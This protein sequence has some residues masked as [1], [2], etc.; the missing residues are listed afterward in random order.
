M[1][2]C[3]VSTGRCT[4]K[5]ANLGEESGE[6]NSQQLGEHLAPSRFNDVLW[7]DAERRRNVHSHLNS[8]NRD[9]AR[10]VLHFRRGLTHSC[11]EVT[12]KRTFTTMHKGAAVSTVC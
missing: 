1:H 12:S 8:G 4:S 5:E 9:S 3:R 7:D 11:Q 10:A 6:G 2:Y